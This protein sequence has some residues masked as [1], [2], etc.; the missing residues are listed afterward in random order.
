M[1]IF[2]KTLFQGISKFNGE[3][4]VT[5]GF[6]VRRLVAAGYTQSRS[7]NDYGLT[8]SYW[9]GFINN[10]PNL[11]K[12]SRVL[13]LGVGGGTALKLLTNKFGPIAIDAVEIDPLMIELAEKYFDLTE[14]NV[15]IIIG[16]A[17]KFIKD[18][19]YKYDLVCVDLFAHGDVAVGAGSKEFFAGIKKT[20]KDEGVVAINKLFFNKKDLD[21]YLDFIHQVFDRTEVLVVK[22]SLSN[23]NVIVYA[24][25]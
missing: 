7:L 23:E 8:G 20:I 4:K 5:E 2:T 12:D 16:D 11:K 18:A 24:T 22:G 6:G 17:L 21:E 1:N 13:M 15:N 19:R 3:I 14:K 10:I 9:D 25:K